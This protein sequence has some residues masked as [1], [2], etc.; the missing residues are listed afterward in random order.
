LNGAY[1]ESPFRGRKAEALANA[2]YTIPNVSNKGNR[3]L[4]TGVCVGVAIIIID[5]YV[6]SGIYYIKYVLA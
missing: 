3:K 2:K 4:D 5:E 6:G 1:T